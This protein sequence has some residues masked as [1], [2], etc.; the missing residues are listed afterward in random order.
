MFRYVNNYFIEYSNFIIKNYNELLLSIFFDSSFL[1]NS[2]NL[3]NLYLFN[4]LDLFYVILNI[5]EIK[6]EHQKNITEKKN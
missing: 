2:I 6:L 3:Y 5:E 4:S 1:N